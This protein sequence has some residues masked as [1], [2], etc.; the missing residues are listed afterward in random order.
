[1]LLAADHDAAL[2]VRSSKPCEL[3]EVLGRHV[4]DYAR[5]HPLS[6]VQRKAVRAIIQ[7]RTAA[8]GGH[9]EWCDGCGFERYL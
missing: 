6:A 2:A 3:A 4:A 8:L 7:C 5:T 9:R 1:M